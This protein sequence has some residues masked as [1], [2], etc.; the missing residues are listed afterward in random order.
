MHTTLFKRVG[1]KHAKFHGRYFS[2]PLP[3]I[4]VQD[5]QLQR[6][7]QASGGGRPGGAT[8]RETKRG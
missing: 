5:L 7:P 6:I 1:R 3:S 2:I 8:R 4:Q